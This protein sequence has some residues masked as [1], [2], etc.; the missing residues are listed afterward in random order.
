MS[1]EKRVVGVRFKRAGRI[2]YFD[3]MEI[4]LK[5]NEHVV[6]ET[7]RGPSIG[8]VVIA[9]KQVLANELTE[10]LKPVLRKA[11]P[12]D[13]QQQEGGRLREQEAISKCLEL[14]T[15]LGLP[16]RAMDAESN[17]DC[18]YIT[19]F[20][21]AEG[22]IDFR[23]LVR[24]L[25]ASLKTRVELH[26]VGP[27]DK[28][29]LMGGMGT[30]G[31]PLCCATFLTEFNPLSIKIAKEQG[32]SLE[33]SKIS[34]VCGRLLCCLGYES[35]LYRS[36]KAQLPPTGQRVV[37]P[38]GEGNIVGSNPLKGTVTVQLESQATVELPVADVSK[39]DT[40][41]DEKRQSQKRP[42]T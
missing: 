1:E 14:A 17:L 18:S 9:P 21:S 13:V 33:P 28:A 36:M 19:I 37:T 32:L 39:K 15:R 3:P 38:V 8:R 25:A 22:R 4:E 23:Q 7:E 12:E 27:R 11:S 16:I 30:C 42:K 20:F 34:G 40:G 5:T 10:P 2:Y 31:Y 29:K 35:E 26:Q 24:E 41:E 6:V